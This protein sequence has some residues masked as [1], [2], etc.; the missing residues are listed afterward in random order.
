[1]PVVSDDDLDSQSGVLEPAELTSQH[2]VYSD[3]FYSDG[4]DD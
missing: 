3:G 1:M 2:P 4:Y